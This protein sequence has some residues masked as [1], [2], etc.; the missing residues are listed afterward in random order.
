MALL[1][2]GKAPLLTEGMALL[3]E[4]SLCAGEIY[5][6]VPPDGGRARVRSKPVSITAGLQHPQE[7]NQIL[8]L[9]R[10]QIELQN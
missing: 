8:L 1:T 9:L 3:T 4:G 5:K 7:R 6:H 2:E 10:R